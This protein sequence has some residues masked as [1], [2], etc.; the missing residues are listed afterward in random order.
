MARHRRPRPV[1]RKIDL[2]RKL[3][4]RLRPER[5][6]A[7]NRAPAI[8]LRTQNRV[9]PQRVVGILHRQRRQRRPLALAPRPIALPQIPQQRRQRPAV[10]GNVM[11]HQQQHVLALARRVR[12]KLKQ[13][14]PQRRLDRKIE[15]APRRLGKSLPQRGRAHRAHRQPHRRR[16]RRQDLLP[17]HPQP[18]RE[19]RAQALVTLHHVANRRRQCRPVQIP[20]QPHRQRDRVARAPITGVL[21]L[22]PVEEPQPALRKRQRD[23]GRTRQSTQRRTRRLAILGRDA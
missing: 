13:L 6:L 18:V 7:R 2:I 17:R 8:L 3:L 22:Q 19:D 4:E 1:A 5:K 23:L 10:A 9:L 12:R 11:Q 20:A 21:P 14:R 15:A 16:R